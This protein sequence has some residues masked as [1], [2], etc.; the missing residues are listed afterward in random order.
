[1]AEIDIHRDDRVLTA[2]GM[3]VGRVKH[4]IVDGP[5]HQVTDI[6]VDQDGHEWLLPLSAVR[7]NTGH[8]LTLRS[9]GAELANSAGFNRHEYHAVDDDQL[10]EGQV[11][12]TP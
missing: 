1:M 9:T 8:S 5:S 6:V 3:E 7:Q 11:R 2:D 10:D 12:A 4:V